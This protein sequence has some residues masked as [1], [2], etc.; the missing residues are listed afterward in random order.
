MKP[1]QKFNVQ[2]DDKST[3][4]V[5]AEDADEARDKARR[6]KRKQLQEKHGSCFE[7]A[8]PRITRTWLASD[9]KQ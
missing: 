4:S 1:L 2:F 6:R 8:M 7:I 3:I 5:V 9:S